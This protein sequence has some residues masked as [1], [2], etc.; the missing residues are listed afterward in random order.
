[1]A[2]LR[3]HCGQITKNTTQ[4]CLDKTIL[5]II[6]PQDSSRYSDVRYYPKEGNKVYQMKYRL[7]KISCTRCVLQW[8]YIA[9]N[10][11]GTCPNGTEQV[12]CGPQEEF[13]ACA[14]ITIG[15]GIVIETTT[16]PESTITPDITLPE[17]EESYSPISA[18]IITIV[19]F[20]I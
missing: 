12:G 1:M 15:K 9:E 6:K 8:R 19:S 2:I 7:P 5:K 10:N 18:I 17:S 11:W 4:D 14:D 20:L 16:D 3:L 13:R